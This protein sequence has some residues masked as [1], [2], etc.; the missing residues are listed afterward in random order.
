MSRAAGLSKPGPFGGTL[1]RTL[2]PHLMLVYG[3]LLCSTLCEAVEGH[4]GTWCCL[5][6]DGR[7][8]LTNRV[9]PTWSEY[10]MQCCQS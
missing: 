5:H 3:L 6:Y 1:V 9:E 7:N 2:L 4:L 8:L 10:R